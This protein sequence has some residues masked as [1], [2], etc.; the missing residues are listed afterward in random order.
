MAITIN[1]K[2][3]RAKELVTFYGLTHHDVSKICSKLGFYPAMRV[4]QLNEQQI[5]GITK[6]LADLTIEADKRAIIRANIALKRSTGSYAGMRH[7]LG[8]PVRGQRTKT[9][10]KTARRLNRI[11]RRGFAT[12]ARAAQGVNAIEQLNQ[13]LQG[14]VFGGFKNFVKALF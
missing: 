8:L 5:L 9:N 2:A 12:D 13:H 10:A 4:H 6:E 11:E 7:A 14:G 3:F 1:G